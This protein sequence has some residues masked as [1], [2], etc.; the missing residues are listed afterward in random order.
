MNRV[1]VFEPGSVMFWVGREWHSHNPIVKYGLVVQ[2]FASETILDYLKLRNN[3]V[4]VCADYPDGVDWDDFRNT[5]TYHK[6][7]K[8][9]DINTPLYTLKEKDPDLYQK[10]RHYPINTAGILQAYHDGILAVP[11][12][13]QFDHLDT[14]ITKDGYQVIMKGPYY[15]E[16]SR[17]GETVPNSK[18]YRTFEEATK[19]QDEILAE[20]KRQ[21]SLTDYEWSVEQIDKVLGLWKYMTSVSQ[22]QYDNVRSRLLAMKN[23]EDLVVRHGISGLQWK[24]EK[25][26]R[27]NNIE[28]DVL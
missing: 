5:Y 28:P 2:Q 12:L 6:L 1:E 17:T 22:E 16:D 9:W 10:V 11:T 3:T 21:A 24:Y 20:Y 14:N 8:G 7:P 18:L 13:H 27:W 4:I 19:E 23:V 15:G 25:N 26:S